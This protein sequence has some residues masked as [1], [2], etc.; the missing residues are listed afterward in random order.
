MAHFR[1]KQGI[2]Q[3]NRL[4]GLAFPLAG[5]GL[6]PLDET[7]ASAGIWRD[8]GSP[9]VRREPWPEMYPFFLLGDMPAVFFYHFYSWSAGPVSVQDYCSS[10]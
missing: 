5:R 1:L 3:D 2:K 4:P 6:F 8:A 10:G 7:K 9:P